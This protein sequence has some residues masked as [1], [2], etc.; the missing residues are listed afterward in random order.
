MIMTKVI[1]LMQRYVIY[2]TFFL[3][4]SLCGNAQDTVLN[5]YG[6]QI[7]SKKAYYQKMVVINAS[8]QMVNLK[9]HIPGAVLRLKY[10]TTDNFM[11]IRLYKKAVAF[12]RKPV[13]D[14]L[15]KVQEELN[16]SGLGIVIY[17]AYRPYSVTEKMWE[18]VKDERYAANPA[19]G[20]GHN[21]GAAVD[22][23]II[24]H[25]TKKELDMGTGFDHFSDTAHHS[26]MHLP[27]TVLKNRKML[28]SIMEKYGFR[29]LDTE[30]WHYS[31]P[32]A[33]KYEL[34][35]LRFRDL[36]KILK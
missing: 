31:I 15:R 2:I 22:L 21:R 6:L 13:A 25:T 19:T 20:S 33:K 27:E 30:W 29:A 1:M 17:D 23:S 16:R 26:F 24:N 18:A 12:L 32:D 3:S 11:R 36:K 4:T 5:K 35:D 8:L 34:L 10:A 9:T 7:I 28:K 14:S